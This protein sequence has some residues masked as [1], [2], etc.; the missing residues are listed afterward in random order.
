MIVSLFLSLS[1]HLL[2]SFFTFVILYVCIYNIYV[3]MYSSRSY[4]PSLIPFVSY[5]LSFTIVCLSFQIRKT[6]THSR[7]RVLLSSLIFT[8]LLLWNSVLKTQTARLSRLIIKNSEWATWR[9]RG[10][11][12]RQMRGDF[13]ESFEGEGRGE[14]RRNIHEREFWV[15]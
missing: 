9:G 15:I 14:G 5:P 8:F 4:I 11:C 2:F 6:F 3:Y 1:F 12:S 13:F 7:A 10:D